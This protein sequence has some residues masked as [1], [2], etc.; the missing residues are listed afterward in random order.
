M[1]MKKLLLTLCF[2]LCLL[3]LT[4]CGKI[5]NYGDMKTV[6]Y[7]KIL[8]QSKFSPTK[9]YYVIVHRN[10]CAVCEGIMP[11]V[12]KYANNVKKNGG[13]PIYALNKSDKKLNGAI[14]E[15]DNSG[16]NKGLGAT[17]YEDI[18]L[19]SSPVLLRI[20]DGQVV[21]LIDTRTKILAELEQM[22]S[23]YE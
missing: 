23:K 18:K 14:G 20:K 5:E 2:L 16:G 4:S 15:G 3:S 12:A 6:E 13:D 21:K 9:A 7:K 1:T 11:E 8:N 17:N 22:N 10:G 19:Y